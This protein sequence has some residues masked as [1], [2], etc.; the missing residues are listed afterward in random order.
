MAT[1]RFKY[2]R[3]PHLPW[4]PGVSSDDLITEVPAALSSAPVVVTEK[5]D[6]E[7][8][9]LYQDGLHARSLDGRHHPSRDWLKRL[10]GQIGYQIPAGFRV[11]GEN[12]YA[13]HSVAY[14]D[15]ASYFFVFSIWDETN[16]CLSWA[17]TKAWAMRLGL[18]LV[19][20]LY[21]GPYDDA[22]L[23]GLK[24]DLQR[25][26]GYVVRSAG[27]FPYERFAEHV[28]KWVRRGHVQTDDHWMHG[29]VTP[30]GPREPGKKS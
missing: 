27:A 25:C 10:Q 9:T 21:E 18:E 1:Q 22:W 23:R 6:G 17:E 19:P 26:E 7:N 28:A 29:V 5:L 12:L 15:L 14:E 8:S 4:S 11:C 13:R 2:P 16:T 20:T 30:N 3:T 24:L